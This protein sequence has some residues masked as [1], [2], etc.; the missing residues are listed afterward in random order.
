MRDDIVKIVQ[1][2]HTGEVLHLYVLSDL[3]IGSP[4]FLPEKLKIATEIITKDKLACTLFLG[5]IIDADRPTTRL[6][7]KQMFIDRPEAREDEDAGIYNFLDTQ[8][9]PLLRPLTK[10]CIG[11]LEGDHYR[12]FL[13]GLTST[14]YICS[15]LKVDY[16]G[17][18]EAHID[19]CFRFYKTSKG[20]SNSHVISINARHG[21]GFASSLAGNVGKLEKIMLAEEN[22]DIYLRG[23][24]HTPSANPFAKY[25]RDKHTHRTV[26]RQGLL[27]NTASFRAG[28]I[29]GKVDYAER[30]EYKATAYYLNMIKFLAKKEMGRQVILFGGEIIPL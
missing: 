22:F 20:I 14:Q 29:Q 12:E 10:N 6:M 27:F 25:I 5:D 7:R 19:I 13:G 30:Q 9:I 18:G 24:S 8:I 26:Q 16:L 28:K 15:Q 3:H 23:H 2:K 17:Q 4:A 21:R 11:F 1:I